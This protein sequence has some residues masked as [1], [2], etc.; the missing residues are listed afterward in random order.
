[1]HE[2]GLSTFDCVRIINMLNICMR[3]L[4]LTFNLLNSINKST[5]KRLKHTLYKYTY[6]HLWYY[7]SSIN[8]TLYI[9]N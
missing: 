5:T 4:I 2:H 1:M 8:V 9:I 7:M 6:K 3:V